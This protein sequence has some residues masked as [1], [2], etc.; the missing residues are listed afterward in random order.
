M[1]RRNHILLA[2]LAIALFVLAACS[3]PEPTPTAVAEVDETEPEAT[4]T[5]TL[6]PT[7]EPTEVPTNTPTAIP[8]DT[9]APT[10]TPT[11]TPTATPVPLTTITLFDETTGDPLEGLTVELSNADMGLTMTQVTDEDGVAI[12]EDLPAGT[13]DMTVLNEDTPILTE[14]EL[15]LEGMVD[16]AYDVLLELLA[17]VIP[18]E[19]ILN[20]GPDPVYDNV[21][22]L[23]AGDEVEI[24][25]QN[26]DG[27]WLLVNYETEDGEL[28]TGWLA[29]EDLEIMGNPESVAVADAPPTPTPGPTAVPAT[30][31]PVVVDYITFYYRSNP[32]E[33]LGTFPVKTFNANELY[34]K[35]LLV[36]NSLNTMNANL[37]GARNGDAASCQAYVNAYNTILNNG[38]F[39]DDVPGDWAGI[40]D[41]YIVAFIFALDRTRPAFLSCRDAGTVDNF[42]A[43]LAVQ[44]IGQTLAFFNP[45]VDA[46]AAKLP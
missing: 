44:T 7:E 41:A 6:E 37:G 23:V 17:T 16:L 38:T 30:P 4:N 33:I 31:A 42:N 12:F 8:T 43:D 32:S 24:I 29:A 25:G 35:M 11:H 15:D 36:R 9:P 14:T 34:N 21:A 40:H 5:P 13:Y 3:D 20:E 45:F 19:V 18:D 26:D 46:A 28:L 2:L 27:S 22:T 1:R 10:E 39:Y